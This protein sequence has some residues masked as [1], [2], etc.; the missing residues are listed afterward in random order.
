MSWI[1]LLD[2]DADVRD[3]LGGSLRG[4]G[5]EVRAFDNGRDALQA[6][7]SASEPPSLVVLDLLLPDMAGQEVL[8]ALRAGQSA[9]DVPVVVVTGVD[10][11]DA[12]LASFRVEAIFRKPV[13]LPALLAVVSRALGS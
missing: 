9:P 12:L 5:H 10:A 13:P 11:A 6:I 8:R 3:V 2:A 4:A 1:C 7:E